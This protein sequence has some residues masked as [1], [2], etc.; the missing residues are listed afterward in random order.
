MTAKFRLSPRVLSDP[1][2]ESV[3]LA[4]EERGPERAALA[5]RVKALE[6]L[7]AQAD[8]DTGSTGFA[9]D[10][11]LYSLVRHFAPR[12]IAEVGTFIGKSTLAL[13]SALDDQGAAGEVFTCDGSNAIALPW[14]GRAGLTQFPKTTSTEML[15]R[16]EGPLDMAFLDGRLQPDDFALLEARL[17]PD[18][19]LALDD[20]EGM[21]KGVINLTQLWPRERFRNY[22]LIYPPS[23]GLLARHGFTSP[24][25]VAVLLPAASF[26]FVRQG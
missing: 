4:D 11:C 16:I 15:R 14:A 23:L 3:L 13:L 2:W 20:F 21:E 19:I 1:F 5:E 25:T 10:W 9:T 24:S 22:F 26:V 6:A 18:A 12:R 8:Y 7:R 17:A